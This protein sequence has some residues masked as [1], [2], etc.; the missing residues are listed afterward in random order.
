MKSVTIYLAVMLATWLPS[1]AVA[2]DAKPKAETVLKSDSSWTGAPYTAYPKGRPELTVL[3]I[4]I[5]AHSA[6]PWHTHVVPNAAYVIS[7]HLTV[8]E[9]ATGR[10]KVIRAGE[11]L[12]ESVGVVH[13][14]VTDD[15][16]VVLVVMYAGTKDTPLSVP[17]AEDNPEFA[18]P[19]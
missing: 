15:E 16:E 19:P 2:A 14:G 12:P 9:K 4:V 11:A 7:G 10:K 6:L 17:L 5:P 18:T 8:E 3:R 13:R 1:P